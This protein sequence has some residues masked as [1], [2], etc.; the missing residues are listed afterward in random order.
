M[1][2]LRLITG[3]QGA[4]IE[5]RNCLTINYFDVATLKAERVKVEM[6][7]YDN[8]VLLWLLQ[9]DYVLLKSL[10]SFAY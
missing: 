9:R 2:D 8:S 1:N 10:L 4:L 6:G 5:E 7:S 3:P